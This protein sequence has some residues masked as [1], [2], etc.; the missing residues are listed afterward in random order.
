VLHL[1]GNGIGARAV[2]QA[3]QQNA[4]LGLVIATVVV[5]LEWVAKM[6]FRGHGGWEAIGR[7]VTV[8]S[9]GSDRKCG[10]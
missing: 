6:K 10:A 4:K 2:L 3:G 9:T 8:K 7:F 5:L 1:L